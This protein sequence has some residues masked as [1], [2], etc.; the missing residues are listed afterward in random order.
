MI[1]RLQ[2]M[3]FSPHIQRF[4]FI[5]FLFIKNKKYNIANYYVSI[6]SFKYRIIYSGRGPRIIVG[7]R[8]RR[9]LRIFLQNKPKTDIRTSSREIFKCVYVCV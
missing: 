9:I 1:Y 3:M 8:F 5:F 7:L 6:I 4:F 2:L